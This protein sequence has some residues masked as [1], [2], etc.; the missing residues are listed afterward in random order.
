MVAKIANITATSNIKFAGTYT[1]EETGFSWEIYRK[2]LKL[3]AVNVETGFTCYISLRA[4]KVAQQEHDM[5][6]FMQAIA[7]QTF[8]LEQQLIE[9]RE[10]AA[11]YKKQCDIMWNVF[12]NHLA[13]VG[14]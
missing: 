10:E 1:S 6:D 2:G 11:Y 9:A 12:T 3:F 8:K 13:S 14:L 4:T 7:E 5:R